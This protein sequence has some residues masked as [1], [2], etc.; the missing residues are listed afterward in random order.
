MGLQSL[1]EG[2]PW[3]G[4]RPSSQLRLAQ[5]S[6]GQGFSSASSCS[7]NAACQLAA[8]TS[9]ERRGLMP[10]KPGS[11][12]KPD[13]TQ[14]ALAS[15]SQWP[16]PP[17]S[18]NNQSRVRGRAPFQERL[19][20]NLQAT[21]RDRDRLPGHRAPSSSCSLESPGGGERCPRRWR[22]RSYPACTSSSSVCSPGIL[23]RACTRPKMIHPLLFVAVAHLEDLRP[24]RSCTPCVHLGGTAPARSSRRQEKGIH[25]ALH[26][27]LDSPTQSLRLE[28]ELETLR[29][30]VAPILGW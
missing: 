29:N 19:F 7:G 3:P 23:F 16:F 25:R 15:I 11:R 4:A 20:D 24:L 9:A 10:G 14:D 8:A 30:L 18:D 13:A 1:L 22:L 5:A 26:R 27:H 21:R 28:P 12:E 6:Q 2:C 17:S